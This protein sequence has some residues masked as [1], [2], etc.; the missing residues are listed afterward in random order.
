[1]K[2]LLYLILIVALGTGIY[3][4]LKAVFVNP[5]TEKVAATTT[6]VQGQT[7]APAAG[8]TA[9]AGLPGDV[10][11]VQAANSIQSSMNQNSSPINKTKLMQRVQNVNTQH[12]NSIEKQ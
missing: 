6:Q 2:A 3:W 7:A 11:G 1:M 10:Q 8:T 12:N 5:E 4:F 9:G